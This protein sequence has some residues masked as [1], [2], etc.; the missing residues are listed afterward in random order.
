MNSTNI[1]KPKL[2]LRYKRNKY[3]SYWQE[4][5]AL[6]K[7]L[8]IQTIRQPSIIITGIIQSFLWLVLFGALFQNA[9]I[10]LLGHTHQYGDFISAGIIVF[11][12]FTS[13]LYAGLP[14]IFDREFGFLNRL[15][16]SPIKSRYCIIHASCINIFIISSIQ[17]ACIIYGC[18][19]LNY[20][21]ISDANIYLVSCNLLM[22][23]TS[24]T[25]L[26][27][28]LALTVP[29]H[30]ELLGILFIINLPILFSST[31]LAPLIFMPG[32]LQIIASINPL[33]YIIE[34]IRHAYINP[35][36]HFNLRIL[37]TSWGH[38]TIRQCITGLSILNIILVIFVGS[39][40]SGKFEE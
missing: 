39:L 35:D 6:T 21:V 8:L 2:N 12:A 11:T 16:I 10:G 4:I 17:V 40:I 32:W 30:I 1:L 36:I 13:A 23:T 37:E 34:I 26:S 18:H 20:P 27:I 28:I 24:T 25:S 31:A 15:L 33:T 7:R 14:L 3:I 22:L 19:I 9:P 5:K 38:Y 29:G